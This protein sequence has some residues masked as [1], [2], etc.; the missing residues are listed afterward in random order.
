MLK[1]LRESRRSQVRRL[2]SVVLHVSFGAD[3]WILTARE[4]FPARQHFACSVDEYDFSALITHATNANI[5]NMALEV[6]PQET[7]LTV[8][9]AAGQ[10]RV[11]RTTVWRW[12]ESGRLA[13][14]RAGGR[15]IR[16]RVQ[17]MQA[18][19]TPV[20]AEAKRTAPAVRRLAGA[21]ATEGEIWAG[22]NPARVKE[23][24]RQ[25]AGALASVDPRTLKRDIR[26][27]RKQ[28]SRGRPA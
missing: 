10:L 6:G 24:L 16:I 26:Q 21:M 2:P 27:A 1:A 9:E 5:C 19:L 12:I 28:A 3:D 13:A 23:A 20:S 8:A 15:T 17:D 18:L 25:S 4:S 7:Y 11:S 14:Y 22:Y